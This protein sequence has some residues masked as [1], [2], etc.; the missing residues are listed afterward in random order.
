MDA[1]EDDKGPFKRMRSFDVSGATAVAWSKD[2]KTLAVAVQ[3][4][5][6]ALIDNGIGATSTEVVAL[7]VAVVLLDSTSG[8]QLRRIEGFP[9]NLPIVVARVAAR[10]QAARLRG[11]V[12]SR[13]TA[14]R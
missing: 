10:R 12:S 4:T 8:K 1:G 13:T 3:E 14:R 5:A 11:R 2:G 7:P 6:S 9:D